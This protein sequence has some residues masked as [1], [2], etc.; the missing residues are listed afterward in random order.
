MNNLTKIMKKNNLAF[1]LLEIMVVI[2]II[3]ILA[4]LGL[5]KYKKSIEQA[6]IV[7]E[8]YSNINMIRALEDDYFIDKGYYGGLIAIGLVDADNNPLLPT[9]ECNARYYFKYNLQFSPNDAP[10][11]YFIINA[12][13]CVKDGKPPQATRSYKVEKKYYSDGQ[14]EDTST[15]P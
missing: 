6:G 5:T 1:T 8:A 10:I 7:N 11:P 2:V 4:A 12:T 9:D 15:G 3:G 13:R 14:V